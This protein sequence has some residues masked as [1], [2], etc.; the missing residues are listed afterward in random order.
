MGGLIS[1]LL[2][3]AVLSRGAGSKSQIWRRQV[4]AF[5]VAFPVVIAGYA[6]VRR[7]RGE[8]VGIEAAR[9]A[10]AEGDPSQAIRRL[11]SLPATAHNTQALAILAAAYTREK[12]Y[13]A[14]LSPLAGG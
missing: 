6:A 10:L 9:L 3:G 14:M 1:G 11:N 12:Q 7:I 13:A 2:L 5:C 8:L 4:V